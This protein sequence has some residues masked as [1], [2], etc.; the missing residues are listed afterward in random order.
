MNSPRTLPST[1]SLLAAAA[2]VLCTAVQLAG[3]AGLAGLQAAPAHAA[4][5]AV[6]VVEL[7][8][9]VISARRSVA[10]ASAECVA[11]ASTC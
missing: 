7:E 1:V 8:R 2:A 9:V 4:A 3:V 10:L 5:R 6:P 11:V